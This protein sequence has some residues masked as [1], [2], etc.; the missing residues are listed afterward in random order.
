L[1]IQLVFVWWTPHLIVVEV[2]DMASLAL[3]KS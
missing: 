2:V 1:V 3:H